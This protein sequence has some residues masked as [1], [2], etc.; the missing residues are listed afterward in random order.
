[1]YQQ[2]EYGLINDADEHATSS[3]AAG[4][5]EIVTT[6]TN[7][8]YHSVAPGS[9]GQHYFC[10]ALPDSNKYVLTYDLMVEYT[11]GTALGTNVYTGCALNTPTQGTGYTPVTPLGVNS[12][13]SYAGNGVYQLKDATLTAKRV[14][15]DI[16]Q[17]FAFVRIGV[18]AGN[19]TVTCKMRIHTNQSGFYQ[20]LK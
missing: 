1:M 5:A 16:S 17:R 14:G 6:S 19:C 9:S 13:M 18:N 3:T 15:T 2:L 4:T 8:S 20:P 10:I 11:A 12:R 7:A